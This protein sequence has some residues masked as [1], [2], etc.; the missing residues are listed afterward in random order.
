MQKTPYF[1]L[2]QMNTIL[3]TVSRTGGNTI[4]SVIFLATFKGMRV[5]F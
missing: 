3:K 4:L 1:W 5:A 2:S